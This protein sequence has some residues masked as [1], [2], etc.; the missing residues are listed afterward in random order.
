MFRVTLG[1]I[2]IQFWIQLVIYIYIYIYILLLK[3][4]FKKKEGDLIN[5][6]LQGIKIK[7]KTEKKIA[8]TKN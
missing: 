7:L 4:T 5:I 3:N 1:V 6:K 8:R 2:L